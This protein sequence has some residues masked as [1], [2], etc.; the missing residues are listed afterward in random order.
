MEH[1]GSCRQVMAF[2]PSVEW[3]WGLPL[4]LGWIQGLVTG[5]VPRQGGVW[6][7][8]CQIDC[9]DLG[10]W[11]GGGRTTDWCR[12]C[13]I[14]IHFH[15]RGSIVVVAW[16]GGGVVRSRMLMAFF[17]PFIFLGFFMFSGEGLT[18]FS[19]RIARVREW[20]SA[21]SLAAWS[22]ALA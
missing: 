17:F 6:S 12:R 3:C 16:G 11:G 10:G 21:S 1:E 4:L 15:F 5:L 18:V 14:C 13:R 19:V 8:A 7:D 9:G 2:V 22:E 20:D